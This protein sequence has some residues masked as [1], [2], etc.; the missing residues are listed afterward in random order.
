VGEVKP[1]PRLPP[2]VKTKGLELEELIWKSWEAWVVPI[3]TLP[4]FAKSEGEPVEPTC[5]CPAGEELPIP[6]LKL[7]ESQ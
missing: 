7:V 1:I 2:E 4:L 3:L 5:S 6:N